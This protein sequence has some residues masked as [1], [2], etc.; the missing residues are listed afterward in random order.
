MGTISGIVCQSESAIQRKKMIVRLIFV[1]AIL[2]TVFV[3]NPSE[4]S[5]IS[6]FIDAQKHIITRE[7]AM[8]KQAQEAVKDR[9][10]QAFDK[11]HEALM[12]VAEQVHYYATYPFRAGNEMIQNSMSMIGNATSSLAGYLPSFGGQTTEP[13]TLEAIDEASFVQRVQRMREQISRLSG[14][15]V[16]V[17][18]VSEDTSNGPLLE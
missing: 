17:H 10:D 1:T 18:T 16:V 2:G 9:I 3:P 6:L 8:L 15:R 5:V 12:S 13:A 14:L 11:A 7:E 4:G